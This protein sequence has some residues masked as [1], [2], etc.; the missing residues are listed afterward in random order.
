MNMFNVVCVNCN[1]LAT[2]TIGFK[3]M[4]F[5]IGLGLVEQYQIL[6]YPDTQLYLIATSY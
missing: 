5:E 4:L 3:K 1:Y 2:R 6:R